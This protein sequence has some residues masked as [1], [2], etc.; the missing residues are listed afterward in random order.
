MESKV[1]QG[2]GIWGKRRAHAGDGVEIGRGKKYGNRAEPVKVPGC[3]SLTLQ[4]KYGKR[5]A[6][7]VDGV[8]NAAG[9]KKYGNRA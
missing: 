8:E 4:K 6:H 5:R 9:E 2:K 1:R 3:G 7:A